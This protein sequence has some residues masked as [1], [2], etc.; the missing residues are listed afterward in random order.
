MVLLNYVHRMTESK[1]IA[2]AKTLKKTQ[3]I[4]IKPNGVSPK[5]D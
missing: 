1:I 2:K 5:S 3:G 4:E